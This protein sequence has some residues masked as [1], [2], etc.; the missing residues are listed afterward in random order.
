MN[1]KT[2]LLV[3]FL[4]AFQITTAQPVMLDEAQK[5][6]KNAF[7]ERSF[8]QN[9]I[10]YA[11]ISIADHRIE[12]VDQSPA[13]YIFNFENGGFTIIS[14]ETALPP[15]LGYAL[16]GIVPEKGYNEN[17]D[18]FLNGYLDQVAY[19]RENNII[20]EA[21][22]S[23]MW[24][25]YSTTQIG[26]LAVVS[27][28]VVVA[29]LISSQWNQDFPYN[30]LCPEDPEGPGGRV[31]AGCVATAMSM[32]MHYW[33]YPY[34]GTGTHGYNY[35]PYGFIYANFGEADYNYNH[36][37]DVMDGNMPEIALLQH[38]CGVAVEM[39]Y[40]PNGSGAYSWDVPAAIKNHF[41]YHTSASFKQKEDYSNTNW[42]NLLKEQIDLGQP[43]YYS[44]FSSTGG[45]AFVCDG[46]D[47]ANLFHFNFGWG[48]SA[49][50]F[51]TLQSVGGYNS[52]QGA[53]INFIPGGDY[54]YYYTDQQI[55]TGKSGSVEDGSGPVAHY[56]ADANVSWLISPQTPQDS[57]SSITL[58]FKRFDLA[59]EDFLFVYDGATESNSMLGQFT[60]SNLP[61]SVTSTGNEILLVLKS[62]NQQ[63]SNGFLVEYT[64]QSPVWC[65]GLTLLNE[66][67]GEISD[68]SL[69]FDYASN[70]MCKWLINPDVPTPA[71]LY[72]TSFDTEPE[73]DKVF[74]YDY[75]SMELL[76]AYSGYYTP[77][78]M[79]APVTSPSGKFF[80]IFSTNATITS[81]GWEAWYAPD[82]VGINDFDPINDLSLYPNPAGDVVNITLP[83][84]APGKSK[85][86]VFN[87][88]GMLMLEEE[89]R[90][91]PEG[92]YP[93]DVS[94]LKAG[95][96]VV[97]L[98]TP[99]KVYR[100][101]LIIYR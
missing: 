96:Y 19:V 3:L 12:L 76:E 52:G 90:S 6:A 62:N 24:S 42:A 44:G 27:E 81:N 56:A 88:S 13:L 11:D 92:G 101:D 66:P 97:T 33:R 1:C 8:Q 32:V 17:F 10:A 28:A 86:A 68:G 9:P 46:Y 30:K 61:S 15:L 60:G 63:T 78:Q 49:N 72:F 54:P 77:D 43:M 57:I 53:V 75:E 83:A 50:G 65:S 36:M 79:P 95:I 74:I 87:L 5:V 21:G 26:D 16:E 84:A 41:G 58:N 14:A 37:Q 59:T 2:T 40:G 47:D 73:H 35:S 23:E 22:I 45:H 48:G 91:L 18:H 4:V 93:L 100:T 39:M 20:A 80:I 99:N 64:T 25:R 67:Q 38:H 82:A 69:Q 29:P 34:Q 98:H 70:N 31:Y 85:I 89:L 71:T 7:F 94:R 55:I 51:Y